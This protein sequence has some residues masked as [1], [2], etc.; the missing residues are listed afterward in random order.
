M[1]TG[2]EH[3]LVHRQR[4]E[5]RVRVVYAKL[6]Q[7]LE[8]REV[9]VRRGSCTETRR[10]LVQSCRVRSQPVLHCRQ[11]SG[12]FVARSFESCA[13]VWRDRLVYENHD[14]QCNFTSAQVSKVDTK[15]VR[16]TKGQCGWYMP[17]DDLRAKYEQCGDSIAAV[18]KAGNTAC[19]AV[20][21]VSKSVSNVCKSNTVRNLVR[22]KISVSLTL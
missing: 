21:Y 11:G 7:P 15:I 10:W 17:N 20:S 22:L 9:W 19:K 16:A 1:Y 12:A 3:Q 13:I 8:I 18:M 2:A 5:K 14:M 4:K 6:S